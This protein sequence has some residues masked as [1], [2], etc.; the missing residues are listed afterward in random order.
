MDMP[1]KASTRISIFSRVHLNKISK[2]NYLFKT[3]TTWRVHTL[4]IRHSNKHTH[5]QMIESKGA[6]LHAYFHLV[7]SLSLSLSR[8]HTY[9]HTHLQTPTHKHSAHTIPRALSHTHTNTIDA[10]E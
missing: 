10:I 7:P 9:A 6:N 3:E 4:D 8:T 2:R 5:T 1:E